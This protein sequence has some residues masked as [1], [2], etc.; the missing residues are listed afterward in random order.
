MSEHRRKNPAAQGGPL[1][2][3]IVIAVNTAP[4]PNQENPMTALTGR[5]PVGIPKRAT[6]AE[7]RRAQEE[8]KYTVSP[9]DDKGH[10]QKL[11]VNVPPG[12]KR[13]LTD[14]VSG[15]RLSG[16]RPWTDLSHAVRY[17]LVR[18]LEEDLDSL[19]TTTRGYLTRLRAQ[20]RLVHETDCRQETDAVLTRLG[21]EYMRLTADGMNDR[22]NA[23]V[24][25]VFEGMEP[26]DDDD[27]W[28]RYLQ[29]SIRARWP[30]V[31]Q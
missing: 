4:D 24:R 26:N 22:A 19:S 12:I 21:E 5:K 11:V 1:N 13:A 30:K 23:L 2:I 14:L 17:Y 20:S 8:S 7:A 25:E 18:G 3:P 29:D 15:F 6:P 27:F 31:V 9:T 28:A 16:D 10:C